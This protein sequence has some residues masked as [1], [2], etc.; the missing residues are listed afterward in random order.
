MESREEGVKEGMQGKVRC[1]GLVR[2][3]MHAVD[4]R[5]YKSKTMHARPCMQ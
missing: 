2:K 3:A 1:G 5:D 4:H